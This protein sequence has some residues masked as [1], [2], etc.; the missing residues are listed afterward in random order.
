[1]NDGFHYHPAALAEVDE[2][3][4]YYR[5]ESPGLAERFLDFLDRAIDLIVA[6]PMIGYPVRG[7]CRRKNFTRFPYALIYRIMG[8]EEIEI[9]AR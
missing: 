3:T 4:E 5:E 9:V 8:D 6:E 2:A 7:G 1:M